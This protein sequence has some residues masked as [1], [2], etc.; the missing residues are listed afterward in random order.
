MIENIEFITG[1]MGGGKSTKLID[2]IQ[3]A[4]KDNESF[5]CLK[6][7]ID[8]RDGAEIKCRTHSKTYPA[9]TVASDEGA[10][11]S[12]ETIVH[13]IT[14]YNPSIIFMDEIQFMSV[15]FIE[16]LISLTMI[17]GIKLVMAGL[18]KDFKQEYFP[19]S[20]HALMHTKKAYFLNANC[21][22]CGKEAL[23]NVKYNTL[24][25]IQLEGETV[26]VGD[27]GKYGVLCET[28]FTAAL[29]GGERD[30]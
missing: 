3:E 5:I 24:G 14:E 15:T 6:P 8:T 20:Y 27:L 26:E 25:A 10:S 29:V 17:N 12:F 21:D 22:K 1:T 30:D 19:A 16:S 23:H 28:C 9:I 7:S 2:F 13:L 18:L 11:E 4:E